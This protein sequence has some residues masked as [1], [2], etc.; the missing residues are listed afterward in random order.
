MASTVTVKTADGDMGLY[1]VE[2]EGAARGAVVVVQEAFGVNDHIEDVTRRFAAEG[3]RAVAPHVFHR[4]GDPV[5]GYSDYEKIMP[6]FAA[7]SEQGL[8]NDLDATFTYLE[9][10]GFPLRRVG[11]VGFC[12]GGTVAF[13]AA[14]R[15]PVGAAVT[16]YGGGVGEGRFGLPPLVEL[17]ADLQAPWLGLYGDL[18][19]G[20]PVADVEKLRVATTGAAVETEVVRYAEADHGF[21]C[22]A[23][24]SYHEASARDA[25]QRALAWFGGHL[26]TA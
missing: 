11:V 8:L 23:R 4:T 9:E 24:P 2:P 3:Y 18:D 13:L 19:Q 20:I 1:D 16:F 7:L 5:I 26:A 10:A 12:M 15:R 17:G 6:H 14:A 22:D 21:H 25:W